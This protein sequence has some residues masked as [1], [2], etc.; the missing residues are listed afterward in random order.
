MDPPR[1]NDNSRDSVP[2]LIIF[3]LGNICV[4]RINNNRILQLDIICS[5]RHRFYLSILACVNL[6]VL[7]LPY[8][9]DIA[10]TLKCKTSRYIA[11]D[12]IIVVDRSRFLSHFAIRRKLFIKSTV[13][14]F[15]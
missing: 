1:Q 8:Y 15:E 12:I 6:K 3:T 5:S 10:L 7:F 4:L 13:Y 9:C 14:R 2:S 11:P